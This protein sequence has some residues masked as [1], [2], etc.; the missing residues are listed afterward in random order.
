M[1]FFKNRTAIFGLALV[2]AGLAPAQAER[3]YW[4]SSLGAAD[5][6]S[7]GQLLAEDM[8]FELGVFKNGFVPT[9]EN[10][11]QW[12]AN[13]APASRV[14]YNGRNRWMTSVFDVTDNAAP[15]TVGA[16]GY[17]WGFKGSEQAGEWILFRSPDWTWPAPNP[18]SPSH[19][20]W[21]TRRATSVIVGSITAGE[22]D[23]FNMRT[24]AIS[25]GLPPSTGWKQWR[26]LELD[27]KTPLAGP[28][29]DADGD[30]VP[31]VVEFALG[32]SPLNG[33]D[34]PDRSG[35][36]N[37]AKAGDKR[38][39]EIRIPRRRD[40]PVNFTAKVSDDLVNWTSG[41]NVT[42]VVS[43]TADAITLRDRTPIS[44]AGTQRFMRVIVTP[45]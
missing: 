39:L 21:T 30:G 3:I 33:S 24:A 38:H 1:N 9:A 31:N 8:S 23:K 18:S 15:F 6:T 11:D 4:G 12:A 25:G 7:G 35:W 40:R 45:Q 28:N 37:I 5:T 42:S 2:L 32:T 41:T 17:V 27:G 26:E 16:A 13:W 20:N 10:I 19:L 36:F 22:A 44:E 43:D 14:K 34:R 29:E